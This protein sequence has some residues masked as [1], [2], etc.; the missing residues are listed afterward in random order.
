MASCSFEQISQKTE[1]R[2]LWISQTSNSSNFCQYL[3]AIFHYRCNLGGD[4]YARSSS[5]QKKKKKIDTNR[6]PLNALLNN[7]LT[8]LKSLE[9]IFGVFH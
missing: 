6:F 4:F 3:E 8:F 2:W 5:S 9:I 1:G 7:V